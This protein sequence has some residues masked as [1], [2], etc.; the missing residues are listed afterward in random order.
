MFRSNQAVNLH[1][2]RGWWKKYLVCEIMFKKMPEFILLQCS[3][4]TLYITK[5]VAFQDVLTIIWTYSNIVFFE[6][7]V[8]NRTKENEFGP[9]QLKIQQLISDQIIKMFTKYDIKYQMKM[10][11]HNID[12]NNSLIWIYTIVW[13]IQ[14][15]FS[16]SRMLV[17]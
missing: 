7:K 4:P 1:Q 16:R 2:N 8:L 15:T 13:F 10:Y 17:S 11:L 5:L 12:I 3:I 9:S 6:L 14:T